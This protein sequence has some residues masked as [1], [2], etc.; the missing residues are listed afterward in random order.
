[1]SRIEGTGN[2]NNITNIELNAVKQ[3]NTPIKTFG[4]GFASTHTFTV[5]KNITGLNEL[6]TSGKFNFE[7]PTYPKGGFNQI[8]PTETEY[9]TF[10]HL[11][12]YLDRAEPQLCET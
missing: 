11:E 2:V 5:E 7:P 3:E 12:K 6:L 8:N 10:S 4:D 1:M 9:L